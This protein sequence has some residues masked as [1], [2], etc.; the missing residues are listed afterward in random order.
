MN[1]KHKILFFPDKEDNVDLTAVE[2][3]E[4]KLKFD[5]G[6]ILKEQ[7]EKKRYKPDGKLRMRIRYQSSVVNF[8]VG[9]RVELSKW[10]VDTQRCKSGTTHG[11]NKNTAYDIN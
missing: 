4:L 8:N 3:S 7:Y 6:E 10:S 9:Y 1:I 2:K 11:K 5:S